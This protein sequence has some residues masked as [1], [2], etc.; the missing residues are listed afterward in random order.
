[1]KCIHRGEAGPAG[2]VCRSDRLI[3]STG[4]VP[5]AMCAKGACPYFDVPNLVASG[6]GDWAHRLTHAMGLDTV[7]HA[8][9]G[10]CG[11]A[12]RKEWLNKV[13]PFG[14]PHAPAPR[15]CD[16]NHAG[17]FSGPVRRN[18]MMYIYPIAEFEV[19]RWNVEQI[20]R[21]MHLFNGAR[22]ISVMTDGR[23]NSA[24]EVQRAF[25]DE[26]VDAWVLGNNDPLYWEMQGLPLMMDHVYSCDPNEIT[27]YCHAKGVQGPAHVDDPQFLQQPRAKWA[28]AMYGACLDDIPFVEK[29]LETHTFAGAFKRRMV[30]GAP[31][32]RS[33]WHF[34]GT[35]YWF[36]N[37]KLFAIPGWHN[38]DHQWYGAETYP[39]QLVGWG[40]AA[41]LFCDHPPVLYLPDS[42]TNQV[43]GMWE[44]WKQEHG[45]CTTA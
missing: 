27:F 43:D 12:E 3:K 30:H 13:V 18:L 5:E 32:Y 44:Q 20:K 7:V 37:A 11:C 19:W 17:A 21:R 34:S 2:V 1:M 41:G 15:V 31:P 26:R 28:T 45:L 6:I 42:W 10:D 40:Q 36:R 4:R 16:G 25:G 22:V 29:Q 35:F 24:E 9:V 39:G 33:S 38:F 14:K 8:V 23:T